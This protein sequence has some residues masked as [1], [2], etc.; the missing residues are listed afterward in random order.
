MQRSEYLRLRERQQDVSVGI[1]RW[2]TAS[3]SSLGALDALLSRRLAAA[4]TDLLSDA[5]S[6]PG[7]RAELETRVQQSRDLLTYLRALCYLRRHGI[8]PAWPR[9]SVP[10]VPSDEA[11]SAS[12]SSGKAR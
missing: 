4:R 11:S 5:G 6:R 9:G 10:S 3:A 7:P 12:I 8:S 2:D 1:E